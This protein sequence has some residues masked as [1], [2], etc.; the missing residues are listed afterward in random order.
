MTTRLV[1]IV[2]TG[3]VLLA[4]QA[5]SPAEIGIQKAQ[6]RIAKHPDHYPY[7][8]DLAMAYARRARETSDVAWYGKAEE[9]LQKSFTIAPDNFEGLKVET[10]LL[11]GRHE[12]AKALESATKLNRR[13]PDDITVYGYLADANSELGNYADAVAAA[14]W[15]LNIRPGNVP[16]LTRAAYQRELH[17]DADGAIELM[18]MAYDATPYNQNEDRAWLLTQLAH[19]HL[20]NGDLSKSEMYASGALAIFPDYHYALGTLAQVRLAQKRY[21]D[22]ADLLRKRI[23]Q[24]PHAE[25]WYAAAK[26]FELAGLDAEAKRAFAEFERRAL[27]ESSW[28]DNANHELIAYYTDVAGKPAEALKLARQELA[29][30]HDVFTLDGYA[31]ALAASGDYAGADAAIHKALAV[32]VKDPTILSHA[33]AIALHAKLVA[34]AAAR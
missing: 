1:W 25:N 11:L 26:A 12:F 4:G 5:P 31:W 2:L 15:M 27:V 24:A 19:L 10:W 13:T 28:A 22:A 9:T 20:L 30:R 14:Q 32:G 21:Q 8:N 33:A 18:Q 6:V 3:S 23:E 7:Y 29:R 17:G 34:M 16:G